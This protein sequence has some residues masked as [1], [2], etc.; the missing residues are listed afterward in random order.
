[1]L[2]AQFTSSLEDSLAF[3][4]QYIYVIQSGFCLALVVVLCCSA[5]RLTFYCFIVLYCIVKFRFV[6][7]FFV[8]FVFL[9][10]CLP[11]GPNEL[12]SLTTSVPVVVKTLFTEPEVFCFVFF[13]RLLILSIRVR[14]NAKNNN[15]N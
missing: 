8:F 7:V 4:G 6:C 1:V 12:M 14:K 10:R 15:N 2:F 9:T 11:L 3:D 5:V 13:L